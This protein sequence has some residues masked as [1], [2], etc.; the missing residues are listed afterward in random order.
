M[1]THTGGG[2][3]KNSTTQEQKQ[4]EDDKPPDTDLPSIEDEPAGLTVEGDWN[5]ITDFCEQ[6]NYTL[7]ISFGAVFSLQHFLL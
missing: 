2:K 5:K 1:T 7:S 3:G 6:F 4:E